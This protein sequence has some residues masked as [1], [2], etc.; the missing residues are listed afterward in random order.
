M[1]RFVHAF[2]IKGMMME[3]WIFDCSGA[4][5]SGEFDI[6]CLSEKFAHAFVAYMTVDDEAMGLD[7][8]IE[9]KDRSHYITMEGTDGECY[10]RVGL[11]LL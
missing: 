3:L 2:T 7:Q 1:C 8:F 6:P 9:C 4:Y 10:K 5:S 11:D